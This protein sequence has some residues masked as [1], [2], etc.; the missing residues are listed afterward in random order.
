MVHKAGNHVVELRGI[1]PR[2]YIHIETG[3]EPETQALIQAARDLADDIVSDKPANT[4]ALFHEPPASHTGVSQVTFEIREYGARPK[5]ESLPLV[6]R[7]H[8][9]ATESFV[10][11]LSRAIYQGLK[12]AA[13][14]QSPLALAVN[15]GHFILQSYPRGQ[16]PLEYQHFKTMVD[17][18]RASGHLKTEYAS[19]ITMGFG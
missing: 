2:T 17:G 16:L 14:Q 10:T 3:S 12:R 13:R 9:G 18:P 5:L 6:A 7:K 8:V 11:N 19:C 15:F 4:T 1:P